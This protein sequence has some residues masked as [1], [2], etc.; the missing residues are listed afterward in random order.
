M[1]STK[2]M[3]PALYENVVVT[4]KLSYVL[5]NLSKF[6]FEMPEGNKWE[7]LVGKKQKKGKERGRTTWTT[8]GTGKL[9]DYNKKRFFRRID[10]KKRLQQHNATEALKKKS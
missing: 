5:F 6:I 2:K 7:K 9:V 4:I 8:K 10:D 1:Q 3:R